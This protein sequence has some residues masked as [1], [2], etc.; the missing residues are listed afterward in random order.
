MLKNNKYF[1]DQLNSSKAYQFICMYHYSHIGFKRASL[2]LGIYRIDTNELVGVLQWG[3][4][5]NM[6]I[7]LDRYVKESITTAEYLELNRFAMTDLEERNSESQAISLGIKWIKQNRPDIKLLVSYSGRVEGNYGY[8]YQATNW[9]YLGYFI[10]NG[11]WKLDG[12]EKHQITLALEYKKNKSNYTTMKDYLCA[13]YHDVRQY[14]SKQFIYIKRLDKKLTP[15]SP[16]LPYPKLDTEYPIQTKEVIYQEDDSFISPPRPQI[17][18][19]FYVP[20]EQLFSRECLKRRGEIIDDEYLVYDKSGKFIEKY[21]TISEICAKYDGYLQQGISN[22][23]KTGKRYKEYFF[24]KNACNETIKPVIDVN[25]LC[26]ID[27]KPFYK[28]KEIVDYVGVT[29]QAVSSCV[30]KHGKT[31]KGKPIIWNESQD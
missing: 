14:D 7:R 17:E 29:R 19:F 3:C 4:S 10:S 18:R 21:K 2:N 28:Q 6:N 9:E 12:G 15:A 23:I 1:I 24:K 26:W 5:A 8:I 22:S 31:I 11:F 27:D 16:I 30:K 25:I 20:N 13:T